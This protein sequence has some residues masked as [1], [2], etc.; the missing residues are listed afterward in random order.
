MEANTAAQVPRLLL[1]SA[2]STQSHREQHVSMTVATSVGHSSQ[3]LQ[4]QLVWRNGQI[5]VGIF[6]LDKVDTELS[7][8]AKAAAGTM[9]GLLGSLKD[10]DFHVSS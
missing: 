9:N 1:T 3:L 6:L 5:I 2:C 8:Q 10:L 7:Y 4:F